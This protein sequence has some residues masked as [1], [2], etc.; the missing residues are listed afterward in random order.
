MTCVEVVIV[1]VR[2]RLTPCAWVQLEVDEAGSLA[3][4]QI[5]SSIRRRTPSFELARQAV[6]SFIR[7]RPTISRV[8]WRS[9]G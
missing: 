7:L 5:L 6:A 9:Q 1:H 8:N 2:E 3:V 4:G